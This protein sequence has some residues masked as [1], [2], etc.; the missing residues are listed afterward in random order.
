[1]SAQA[2]AKAFRSKPS[3]H[4]SAAIADAGPTLAADYRRLC[5]WRRQHAPWLLYSGGT[6]I[7]FRL[8]TAPATQPLRVDDLCS[9]TA[10]SS[11]EARAVLDE[12]HR[13]GLVSISSGSKGEPSEHVEATN[14]LRRLARCYVQT[15]NHL[16]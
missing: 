7:V 9:G 12:L 8:M 4:A 14:L 15:M 11:P 2:A 1:M 10:V 5:V 16:L 13:K 6:T 3:H